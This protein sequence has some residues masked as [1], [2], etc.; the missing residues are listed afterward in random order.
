MCAW[1]SY[2]VP[3]VWSSTLAGMFLGSMAYEWWQDRAE[4]RRR[5]RAEKEW[6]AALE[7]LWS[8]DPELGGR[9]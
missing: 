4:R 9:R 3:I 6:F 2:I 8:N 1:G 7:K 5:K